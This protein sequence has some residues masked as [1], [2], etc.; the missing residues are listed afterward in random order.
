MAGLTS[1]SEN[2]K[3]VAVGE[4]RQACQIPCPVIPF[5]QSLEMESQC[6]MGQPGGGDACK[7]QM[8]LWDYENVRPLTAS[9]I[10]GMM[11]MSGMM[12][13]ALLALLELLHLTSCK[14]ISNSPF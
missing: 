8:E 7:R 9:S 1:D 14:F 6:V 4:R 10:G 2:L 5:L 13:I 11:R 12:S 3:N